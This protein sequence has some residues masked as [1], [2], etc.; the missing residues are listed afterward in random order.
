MYVVGNPLSMRDW[1]QSA[2][3]LLTTA[4]SPA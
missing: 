2:G 1:S 3:R 4:S